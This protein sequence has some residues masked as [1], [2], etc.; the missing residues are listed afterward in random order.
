MTKDSAPEDE[1]APVLDQAISIQVD[2][3]YSQDVDATDLARTI[4]AA[5]QAEGHPEGELTLVVTGDEE[6]QAL[7]LQY[8]GEDHPTDVLSFPSAEQATEP[9]RPVFVTAPDAAPEAAAYLGD[10]LIA[11]PFVRRQAADLGRELRAEL[12][13]L[14]VHGTL[15][16]LG[17]DHAEPEEEAIMWARQDAILAQVAD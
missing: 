8:L 15:H 2:A 16:L 6:V 9:G 3:R 12:R 13:L 17:Y 1:E 5:L 10:I 4:G 11:L 7:N 14:A